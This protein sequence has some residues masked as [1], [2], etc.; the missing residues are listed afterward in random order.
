ML[1]SYLS[2]QSPSRRGQGTPDVAMYWRLVAAFVL[3]VVIVFAI[4]G[5]QSRLGLIS[6]MVG[7]TCWI[8]LMNRRRPGPRSPVRKWAVIGLTVYMIL[9]VLWFGIDDVAHRFINQGFEGRKEIWLAAFELPWSVWL[10]GIGIDSFADFYRTIQPPHI[11]AFYDYAHS[12]ILEFVL[13]YGLIGTLLV[14][15]S[16]IV[17]MKHGFPRKLDRLQIG[18]LSGLV[19]ILLHSFGD[20]NLHIPGVAIVF[21]AFVGLVFNGRVTNDPIFNNQSRKVHRR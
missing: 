17:W 15:A 13:E 9:M 10:T 6:A 1:P 11:H 7:I 12:D 8:F 14:V 5:S 16:V 18:A 2:S 3:S 21:W 19:A 20:F 4:L